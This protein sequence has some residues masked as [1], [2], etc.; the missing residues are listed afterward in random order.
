MSSRVSS[1]S[2]DFAV[3]QQIEESDTPPRWECLQEFKLIIPC[4]A[5]V[6][7]IPDSESN[8]AF[9]LL[10]ADHWTSKPENVDK[11]A[12]IEVTDDEIVLNGV[13]DL[14]RTQPP[15]HMVLVGV[16]KDV[17]VTAAYLLRVVCDLHFMPPIR[18]IVLEWRGCRF[19][20]RLSKTERL[21]ILGMDDLRPP[22]LR[23][24]R[25]TIK[26]LVKRT[27]GGIVHSHRLRGALD[28]LVF[29][30]TLYSFMRSLAVAVR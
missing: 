21:R 25:R 15:M 20:E 12:D 27:H 26:R 29:V 7:S 28:A 1:L 18:H 13:S 17:E 6:A 11:I 24:I 10:R 16:G 14:K 9:S 30:L 8:F 22:G 3:L 2:L 23:R 4:D 19:R 5:G